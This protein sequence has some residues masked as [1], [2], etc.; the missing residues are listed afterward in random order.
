[1][2]ACHNPTGMYA[3]AFTHTHTQKVMN[4][5]DQALKIANNKPNT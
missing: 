4:N 1:M 2:Y 5:N 3:L